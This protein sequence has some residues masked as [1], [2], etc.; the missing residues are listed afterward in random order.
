MELLIVINLH[1][2]DNLIHIFLFYH[3][4]SSVRTVSWYVW[5][6]THGVVLNGGGW[7]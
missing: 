5:D 4:V 2:Y 6:L 7:V 3:T 1:L